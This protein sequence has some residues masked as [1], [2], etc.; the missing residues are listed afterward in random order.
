[1]KSGI[2]SFRLGFIFLV[3][4]L[5]VSGALGKKNAYHFKFGLMTPS[6]QGNSVVYLET[7]E[8]EKH[9]DPSYGHGF[10]IVRKNGAQFYIYYIV[11]FPEPMKN[12]PKGIEQ[13]YTVL[14]GGRALQSKEELVWELSRSFVFE[15]SDPVGTYQLEVYVDGDLY[16]KIDYNVSAVP[17]FDF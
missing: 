16:R 7:K 12:I 10:S 6:P 9:A 11:R 1:M 17:E 2:Q 5:F 8:I 13:F 3:M 14:E 15:K 4:A